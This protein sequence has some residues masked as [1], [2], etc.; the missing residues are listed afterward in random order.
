MSSRFHGYRPK[1]PILGTRSPTKSSGRSTPTSRVS[2]SPSAALGPV[3]AA[4]GEVETMTGVDLAKK[5]V[6]DQL[7]VSPGAA[8][9]VEREGRASVYNFSARPSLSSPTCTEARA[10]G[11]TRPVQAK[12]CQEKGVLL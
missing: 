3:H 12:S 6:A 4:A 2:P 10:A 7:T 5:A 9:L 8:M 1:S 11:T